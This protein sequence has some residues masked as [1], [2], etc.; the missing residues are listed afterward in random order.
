MTPDE[1][2]KQKSSLSAHKL[3]RDRALAD[4]S[5][6]HWDHIWNQRWVGWISR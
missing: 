2:E 4:E 1:L 5:I 3:A 6:R